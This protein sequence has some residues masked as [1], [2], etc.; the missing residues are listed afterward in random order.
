MDTENLI[1]LKLTPAKSQA[2]IELIDL[3]TKAGGIQV[4]KVA[5]GLTDDIVAAVNA[6]RQPKEE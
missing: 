3:A 5:V 1:E 2:L 6:S 4:A